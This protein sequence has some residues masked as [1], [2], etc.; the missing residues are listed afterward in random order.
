MQ[1]LVEQTPEN[2]TMFSGMWR[3]GGTAPIQ[4]YSL[5]GENTH[6]NV[7]VPQLQCSFSERGPLASVGRD[8]TGKGGY[9]KA[10]QNSTSQPV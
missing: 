4:R 9:T 2:E 10:F 5:M 8:K 3:D 7:R 1:E 6:N